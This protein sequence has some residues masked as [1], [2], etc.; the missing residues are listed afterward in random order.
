MSFL[1]G[2]VKVIRTIGEAETGCQVCG[3]TRPAQRLAEIRY[4]TVFMIPVLPLQRLSDYWECAG[5]GQAF[6][7]DLALEPASY[8]VIRKVLAYIMSGY[9][10]SARGQS[11]REICLHCTGTSI[12]PEVLREE[13]Q[14]I[15]EEGFAIFEFLRGSAYRLNC[16]GKEQ[17]VEAAVL[18]THASCEIQEQD[19]IRI[20]L[21]GGALGLNVAQVDEVIE[22]VRSNRYY[23]VHRN[24][25]PVSS[26]SR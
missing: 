11:I 20:N 22:R 9:G 12:A 16:K 14:Q 26:V 19:H 2:Q 10:G 8:A 24:L 7:S 13:M 1:F 3:A 23:G 21:I 25:M 17:V 4:F 18:M 6:A 15:E 5:C